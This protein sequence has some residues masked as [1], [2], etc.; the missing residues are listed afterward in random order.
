MI[1]IREYIKVKLIYKIMCG[2]VKGRYY[3]FGGGGGWVW[4]YIVIDV[5]EVCVWV[6]FV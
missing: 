2:F 1:Y 3:R 5:F 6:G 4:I